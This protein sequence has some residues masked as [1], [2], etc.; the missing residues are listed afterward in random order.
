[1][2]RSPSAFA[3]TTAA[4]MSRTHVEEV[5][6]VHVLVVLSRADTEGPY[7]LADRAR[8]IT[9]GGSEARLPPLPCTCTMIVVSVGHLLSGCQSAAW[10]LNPSIALIDRNRSVAPGNAW[11][12][13]PSG[14]RA[15][16]HSTLA[17]IW[18]MLIEP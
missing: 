10:I 2:D 18:A 6:G 14:G 12:G 7:P 4:S 11:P 16:S 8:A 13:R 5:V 9:R 1:M 3:V 17:A 15:A